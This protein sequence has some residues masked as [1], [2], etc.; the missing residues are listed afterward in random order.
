MP[1]LILKER[2]LWRCSRNRDAVKTSITLIGR[3]EKKCSV[4]FSS[5]K[6]I[7]PF[8]SNLRLNV[9]KVL[10]AS[11]AQEQRQSFLSSI[12]ALDKE[13]AELQ[14]RTSVGEAVAKA[15]AQEAAKRDKLLEQE[16]EKIQK[17]AQQAMEQRILSDL[18]IQERQ[19]AL[20]RWKRELK[21]EEQREA[22][23]EIP[24]SNTEHEL[25]PAKEKHPV[26]HPILGPMLYDFGYKRIHISSAKSLSSIPI[27]SQQRSYRH[28]RA[29]IMAAEKMRTLDLGLPGVISLHEVRIV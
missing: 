8:F 11:L 18:I 21:E 12:G 29:K 16:Q 4:N 1:L 9:V 10:T 23:K 26:I 15:I 3:L 5:S 2:R 6:L 19:K 20:E 17:Q 13:S 24:A 22:T 14:K 27:W 25:V 7:E 28:D